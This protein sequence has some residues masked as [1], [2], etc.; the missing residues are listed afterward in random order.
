MHGVTLRIRGEGE[1]RSMTSTDADG[2]RITRAAA[3]LSVGVASAARGWAGMAHSRLGE[4]EREEAD[5][6]GA[7]AGRV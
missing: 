3:P 2:S 7:D 4:H 1:T 5:A 6:E